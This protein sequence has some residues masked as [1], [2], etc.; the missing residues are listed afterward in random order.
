MSNLLRNNCSALTVALNSGISHFDLI[1]KCNV[2][3]Y[4]ERDQRGTPFLFRLFRLGL[5]RRR[6]RRLRLLRGAAD[7][8][9]GEW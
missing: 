9:C 2:K 7:R 3:M 5:P 8:P 1:T 4:K 6:R